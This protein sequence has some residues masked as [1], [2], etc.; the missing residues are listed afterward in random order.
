MMPGSWSWKERHLVGSEISKRF[1]GKGSRV[2]IL[3][4]AVAAILAELVFRVNYSAEFIQFNG[5]GLFR[6]P[7]SL[8]VSAREWFDLLQNSPLVG[9]VLLDGADIPHYETR[10]KWGLTAW[11]NTKL[12]I[13]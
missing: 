12:P 7:S 2:L 6:I 5:F 1:P 8:P 4:G 11:P 9:L 3:T 10:T 13:N